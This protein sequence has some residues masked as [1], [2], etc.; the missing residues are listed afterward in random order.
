MPMHYCLKGTEA[1]FWICSIL[2]TYKGRLDF[3]RS[4]ARMLVFYHFGHSENVWILC[5]RYIPRVLT[6]YRS[7]GN[8]MNADRRIRTNRNVRSR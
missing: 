6:L 1:P 7:R 3:Y 4:A 5:I 2:F 8:A